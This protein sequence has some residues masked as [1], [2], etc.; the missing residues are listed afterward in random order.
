MKISDI[1]KNL[2]VETKLPVTNLKWLTPL[3]EPI[4]LHG[5]YGYTEELG[6]IRMPAEVAKNTSDGVNWL[7][8]NTAGG[9]I[10]LKTNSKNIAVKVFVTSSGIMPHITATGQ[11]GLD[12]YITENHK[13][14][15]VQSLMPAFKKGENGCSYESIAYVSGEMHTYTM[16]M[17]LYSDVKAIYI[18]LDP[19]AVLEKADDYAITQPVLYYG[20]SITQGG[21]A[22]RPGNAYQAMISRRFDCD[23]INLGFSG[24]A[25]A[26]PA[27]IEYLASLDPCIFVLDYD[28]NAPNPEHLQNTHEPLF[29]AF[30]AAHPDTPVIM[31]S[32]P[33]FKPNDDCIRRREIIRTTYNNAAAA[34]DKNVYFIDGETLFEGNC[35]DSCTV[36]GCH[37][38][39]LGFFR[40]AEV[41]GNV[42]EPLITE[43][44]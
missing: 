41:I 1:D 24:S 18:G 22:S 35:R 5:I 31:V 12:L 28:H 36:D 10:R 2:K 38:N 14:T 27:M 39:D 32:K 42:M 3:D 26:E 29:K 4:S 17:P 33:D 25:R 6:Y 37:P 11:S 20:S 7:F 21:C 30:R 23:F 15:Y 8:R 16:N 34:G 9:R 13:S 19:D 40:M 44:K 43:L